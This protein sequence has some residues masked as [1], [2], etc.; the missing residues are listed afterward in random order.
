MLL[1]SEDI[2]QDA[3]QT[4]NDENRASVKPKAKGKDKPSGGD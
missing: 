2:F 1:D 3:F 4:T